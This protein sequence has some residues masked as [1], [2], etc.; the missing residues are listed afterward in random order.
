MKTAEVFPSRWLKVDDLNPKG[1]TALT[2]TSVELEEVQCEDG[3][4]Q[5]KPVMTF[6]ETGKALIVNKT[7]WLLIARQHGD[8][9]DAWRDRVILLCATKV[10]AFKEVW[11]VVRVKPSPVATKPPVTKANG[12]AGGGPGQDGMLPLTDWRPVKIHFGK[13]EGQALGELSPERLQWWQNDWHP[14]PG[15]KDPAALR[16]R[17]ALDES[18]ADVTA[19]PAASGEDDVPF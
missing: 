8:D 13:C 11:P 12:V 15:S 6:K 3:R 7:N 5:K 17:R 9:S 18:L 10:T 1:D 4:K 16:L 19:P 2:I 14:A